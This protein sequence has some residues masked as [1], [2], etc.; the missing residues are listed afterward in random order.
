MEN[1]DKG[2]G[3]EKWVRICSHQS[4]KKAAA[5]VGYGIGRGEQKAIAIA[6]PGF[7]PAY[8]SA[9]QGAPHGISH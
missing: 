8:S 7:S 9:E 1:V 4:W 2:G 3:A 5:T 6:R